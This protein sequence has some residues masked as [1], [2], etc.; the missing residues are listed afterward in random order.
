MST[1]NSSGFYTNSREFGDGLARE[2]KKQSRSKKNFIYPN[3]IPIEEWKEPIVPREV[4]QKPIE[5][6]ETPEEQTRRIV[7]EQNENKINLTTPVNREWLDLTKEAF[8]NTENIEAVRKQIKNLSNIKIEDI[9]DDEKLIKKLVVFQSKTPIYNIE[10]RDSIK[11]TDDILALPIET[12]NPI[13]EYVYIGN[14]FNYKHYLYKSKDRKYTRYETPKGVHRW[15]TFKIGS[16]FSTT[17]N[18]AISIRKSMYGI[19]S[20]KQY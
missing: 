16:E 9:D 8:I 20:I 13:Q 12:E 4:L 17:N 3:Q 18:M 19:S 10:S 11:L 14:L 6:D 5:H 1:E 7:E 2:P 15:N